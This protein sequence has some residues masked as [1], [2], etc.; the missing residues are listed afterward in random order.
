MSI[1]RNTKADIAAIYERNADTLFRLALSYLQ[2]SAD[3]QDAVQ[4]VFALYLKKSKEFTDTSH[5]KAWF[6]R[7]TVNRCLDLLRRKKVRNYIP[8]DE[9]AETI[10]QPTDEKAALAAEVNEY[11]A[12][13]PEKNRAAIVL[14]YLEGYSVE[15]TAEM[16]GISESAV[17]MR[18]SRGREALK[19]AMEKGKL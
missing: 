1:I 7:V 2:C 3:A 10:A 18:L 13:I 17:K 8:I 6:V 9:I 14:H 12:K 5:E 15:E 4:D 16:L 11:L 19:S